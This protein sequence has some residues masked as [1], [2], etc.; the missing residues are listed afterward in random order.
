MTRMVRT[1]ASP[2]FSVKAGKTHYLLDDFRITFCIQTYKWH[3]VKHDLAV[4]C[5]MPSKRPWNKMEKFNG[6]A[7]PFVSILLL[8]NL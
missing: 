3:Q 7:Y 6:N 4:K 2:R 1:L 8:Q 5:K